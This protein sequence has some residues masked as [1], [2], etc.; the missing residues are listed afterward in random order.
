MCFN[1]L[2]LCASASRTN[3]QT[4]AFRHAVAV[5]ELVPFLEYDLHKQLL[6]KLRLLGMN[7]VFGLKTQL[8]VG[9][10]IV[11]AAIQG[12][13]VCIPAL[14]RPQPLKISSKSSDMVHLHSRLNQISVQ[15]V[16]RTII[17]TDYLS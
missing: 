1:N 4:W 2:P 3:V 13:A 14:P 11:I 12:T 16:R 7:A 8:C 5:S 6:Y 17:W 9:D 10:S 15:N